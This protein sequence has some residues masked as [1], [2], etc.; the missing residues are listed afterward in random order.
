MDARMLWLHI[1]KYIYIYVITTQKGLRGDGN[2]PALDELLPS[3]P[4]NAWRWV[5]RG[6]AF[7]HSIGAQRGRHPGGPLEEV[8]APAHT[9]LWGAAQ[10]EK[11]RGGG[12]SGQ[13]C[14]ALK[15]SGPAPP[16][17]VT[18]PSH[19]RC[20]DKVTQCV[21]ETLIG[22]CEADGAIRRS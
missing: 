12:V 6:R 9:G 18:R 21:T 4:L 15:K 5:S 19:T 2:A 16:Q 20:G 22:L 1:F 17:R 7:Q 14:P 13:T 8:Q 10:C 11:G 3:P